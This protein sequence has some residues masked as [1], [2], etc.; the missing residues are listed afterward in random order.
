MEDLCGAKPSTLRRARAL[1]RSGLAQPSSGKEI[2]LAALAAAQS[3]S[4]DVNEGDRPGWCSNL[5]ARWSLCP[6]RTVR[7]ESERLWRGGRG[8]G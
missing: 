1:K 6:D 2:R 8:E 3:T 4:C 7:V 5:Q